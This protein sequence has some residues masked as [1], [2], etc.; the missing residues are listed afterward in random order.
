MDLK[1]KFKNDLKIS[2]IENV[3]MASYTTYKTG[4]RAEFLLLPETKKQLQALY[5]F[6]RANNIPCRVLGLGSNILVSDQGVKGITC[7][8]KNIR[9]ITFDDTTVLA[10]AGLPLDSLIKNAVDKGLEGVE[11]LSGIPG[12][13]GGAVFMNAGAYK[14]E[15]FDYIT[16]VEVMD[17]NG[18]FKTINKADLKP[19]YRHVFGLENFII[20]AAKFELKKTQNPAALKARRQEILASRQ[21]KQPLDY[22]SAGSVFKRPKGNFASKLIDECGLKGKEIGGAKVSTKHAGFIINYN[23]ASAKDIKN[24]MDEAQTCVFKKTGV[25]LEL[26]QILWG[27]F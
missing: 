17:L 3:P 13:I 5:V 26:E 18:N 10:A 11:D 7:C 4:G 6:A 22:P 15:T 25:K 20:I 27:D 23:N 16:Q 24:L 8:L 12:S 9:S 21:A 19:A 2:Y 14:A 1:A